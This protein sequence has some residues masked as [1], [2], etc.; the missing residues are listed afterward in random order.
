MYLFVRET[1]RFAFY[2]FRQERPDGV[3]RRRATGQEVID[4][5]DLMYRVYLVQQQRYFRV[6]R[7]H[8][9]MQ[10]DAIDI[11]FF[12]AFAELELVTHGGNAAI[13]CTGAQCD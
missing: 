7:D 6:A 9:V 2:Q 1:D 13:D 8:P 11:G 4:L 3:S 10:A 12:Q 5:H